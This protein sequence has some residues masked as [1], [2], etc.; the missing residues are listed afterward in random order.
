MELIYSKFE[1]QIKHQNCRFILFVEII[2]AMRSDMPSW[3]SRWL[4][5]AAASF[6]NCTKI[7]YILRSIFFWFHGSPKFYT[8]SFY[9]LRFDPTFCYPLYASLIFLFSESRG[10]GRSGLID[11]ESFQREVI[12]IAIFRKVVS[13][14][15][16]SHY[17]QFNCE[18]GETFWNVNNEQIRK[19]WCNMTIHIIMT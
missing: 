19:S 14:C 3:G 5:I 13:F 4:Y 2:I 18:I 9:F 7:L 17:A 8:L 15:G 12:R 16:F 11:H 1:S 10:G 6:L